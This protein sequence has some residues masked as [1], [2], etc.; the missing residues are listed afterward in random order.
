MSS[1]IANFVPVWIVDIGLIRS[2]GDEA[3]STGKRSGN[4]SMSVKLSRVLKKR[5][6]TAGVAPTLHEYEE[7]FKKADSGDLES[8]RSDYK[9]FANLYYDLVTDFYEFGGGKSFHFA[10]RFPGESFKASLARHEHY[11]AH[12]I[13][14][15]P[16][17]VVADLGCGIG[18]A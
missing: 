9:N 2:Y 1:L 16:G 15:R 11:L 18:G 12:V 10:P 5:Q 7:H 14:L 13:G 17:M 3:T 4:V 8:I 6:E